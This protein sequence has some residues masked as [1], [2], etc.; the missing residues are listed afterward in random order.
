MHLVWVA[1]KPTQRG[2]IR[3][4][5]HQLFRSSPEPLTLTREPWHHIAAEGRQ[6]SPGPTSRP[7][8]PPRQPAE[9][10]RPSPPAP[11]F[12]VV[13]GQTPA[14]CSIFALN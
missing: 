7:I 4:L 11:A 5:E 14:L 8:H 13:G 9:R 12:S 10:H 2:E 3:Q 1:K 6:S